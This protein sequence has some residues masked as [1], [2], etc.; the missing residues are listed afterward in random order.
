[1]PVAGLTILHAIAP[2]AVTSSENLIFY[3]CKLPEGIFG[4]CN[5]HL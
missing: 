5:L 3:F 2:E 4:V 1:M